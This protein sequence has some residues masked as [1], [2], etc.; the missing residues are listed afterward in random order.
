MSELKNLISRNSSAVT[1]RYYISSLCEYKKVATVPTQECEVYL[2]G[3][4]AEVFQ[5]ELVDPR[6]K[7]PSLVK[8]C[9]K[10]IESVQGYFNVL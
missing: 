3:Y 10:L 9:L 7:P 2:F 6:D 4:L 8:T 1:L 5:G